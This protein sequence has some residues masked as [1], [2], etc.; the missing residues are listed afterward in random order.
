MKKI[1]DI[2]KTG[3]GEC[4]VA[5]ATQVEITS[6]DD[7]MVFRKSCDDKYIE[8][9]T[10]SFGTFIFYNNTSD[11]ITLDVRLRKS[12]VWNLALFVKVDQERPDPT[13]ME[14]TVDSEP[15][16]EAQLRHI[17]RTEINQVAEDRGWESFDES[18]D[19]DVDESGDPLSGYEVIEMLDD[20]YHE[21]LDDVVVPQDTVDHAESPESLKDTRSD[22][23]DPLR[24]KPEVFQDKEV[25]K[26]EPPKSG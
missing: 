18:D 19:F 22:S 15:S 11:I 16:M 9:D 4:L 21:E 1:A 25:K 8:L 17:I 7:F 20:D 3:R 24:V 6:S 5:P 13:P 26:L 2:P 10:P 12:S 23:S 14:V